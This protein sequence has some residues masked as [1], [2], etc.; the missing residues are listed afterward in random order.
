[1]AFLFIGSL[2][3]PVHGDQLVQRVF[4]AHDGLHNAKVNDISFD[5]H[6]YTWLSTEEG[7]Y[8]IS[9][10]KSRR[11]DKNVDGIRLS[12]EFIALTE[13]LSDTHLLVS[14][15]ANTYLYNMVSDEFSQFGSPVL[16]SHARRS[17]LLGLSQQNDG[18][19]MLLNNVGELYR[20]DYPAMTLTFINA[21]P[22]DPDSKWL[23]L[24][25]G[26]SNQ[27]ILARKRE[28]QLR[29]SLGM[30]KGVFAW[31]EANGLIKILF[32][33]NQQ[34]V[35]LGASSGL[36]RV[37]PDTLT[38]EKIT[39]ASFHISDIS[40][41]KQ[42]FLWLAGR[43]ELVKWHPDTGETNPLNAQ[44]KSA[45]DL[46]YLH[47]IAVDSND[48]IWVG[49]SGSELALVADTAEFV[50]ESYTQ[51]PPYLLADDMVWTIFSQ[52][53]W[54]W[55]GTDQGLIEINRQQG[56]SHLIPIAAMEVNDSVY[57]I[58]PLDAVHLLIGTT[59]GLFIYNRDNKQVVRF[60]QWTGGQSSLEN[61]IIYLV[62]HDPLLT[63][64]WWFV[65][66]T[67]LFYW[68][69]G[70]DEV[71]LLPRQDVDGK[72]YQSSLRTIYRASDGKLWLGGGDQF[73][74][75]DKLGIYYSRSDVI[76]D[77]ERA[78]DISYISEVEPGLLWLGTSP[79]GLMEYQ[80][81]TGLTERLTQNW[82]LECGSV[83]FIEQ[84]ADYR[85]VGCN[86]SLIRQTLANGQLLV[87]EKQDGLLNNE[88]NDGASF[89]EPGVGLYIGSPN[90]VELIDVTK[91]SNRVVTDGIMLESM[92]IF[93]D[94]ATKRALL[95]EP[96]SVVAPGARM[97]SFQLTSSDFL[98]DAPLQL[99][100]RLRR[101]NGQPPANYVL[102]QGQ[103]QV[104]IAGLS[105]GVYTL[106]ILSEQ[107]GVWSQT[108]FSYSFSVEDY[109]WTSEWFKALISLVAIVSGLYF[110]M[111]RQKQLSAFK[112][113]NRALRESE[114]RLRQSLRGSDSELWEWHSDTGLFNLENRG[115]N[116][117]CSEQRLLISIKEFPI[118][119]E[120]RPRVI[121]AWQRLL[122][123]QEVRIDV[124]YRYLRLDGTWGWTRVSGRPLE[125]DPVT[126]AIK[127]VAGI[128]SDI[129]QQ[130]RLEDDV[131]LLAQA[132]SNTSEGVLILD[133]D[134]R[135][136]VSNRAAQTI[137]QVSSEALIGC[138]FSALLSDNDLPSNMQA[139]N[140]YIRILLQQALTWTGE[141]S[142]YTP[143]KKMCPV[144]LNLSTMTNEVGRV[145]H[146]V[147]VFSD[148]S[149]RKQ[150]EAEL[151]R[152]ANYDVLTGLPNRTLFSARLAQSI[153]RAEAKDETL[154]L[155]FLD[156][157]RFKS[158]N[159]SYGH[160]MGDALLIEAAKRL[161]SCVSDEHTLCRFG[162]DE[163]LILLRNVND[164][165]AINHLCESLIR[166]IELPFELYGREFFISTSI[167][168]SLWP[169]DTKQAETL[170]KNA[171][172]AMYHAK[173]EGRGNFQ[174]YS[175]ERNAQSLY[176][177]K[178]EADLHKA[179][180]RE[181][182]ELHYQ[183]QIDML[184]DD[185]VVGM[186]ALLRWHHPEEGYIR[187]DIFIKVAESCGLII[188]IDR[189]VLK[190]ACMQG[191][192]WAKRYGDE[193]Q[194]SINISAV[195]FRQPDF[196]QGIEQALHTSGMPAHMLGLEITEGVLMKELHIAKEHLQALRIL[197]IDVAIDDFGTGY[198]SLAYLRSFDVSTL[199]VDRSFL[200]DIAN[201]PA[202]QAIVSSIIELARNL[203]LTVVAE[204]VETKAQLE[205]VFSRGCYIIQGYYYA[206]PMAVPE[207]EAYLNA[208]QHAGITQ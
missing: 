30:L 120:D 79:N 99:Q 38:V 89:Y 98:T 75:I 81:Q 187:P 191:A 107:N 62:Y 167:G 27:L 68:D 161:Q 208:Q 125:F 124:D 163:F 29:D 183:P 130:R 83:Y 139:D 4:N 186:E 86:N 119:D 72:R 170:I 204:G 172:Q 76:D 128:Y 64:R 40:Q 42:G 20:F 34:R 159:D 142:F 127:K 93:F 69:E 44:L 201:N 31:T 190:Q 50:L 182:F 150:T 45:A 143:D 184:K 152:L 174:Y 51:E 109:W 138:K 95:P 6:G 7:L 126:G 43:D 200:I 140:H 5:K 178:L 47:A 188:D 199:K 41:D 25:V 101:N 8:R 19:Y 114:E 13:P 144:W 26:E 196:I 53:E 18:S 67:G 11:I 147:A 169:D 80:P 32:E 61:K 96:N 74:Y 110:L 55:L 203:K 92:S 207:F 77:G 162:G 166:Q 63:Q 84:L 194:L 195:H 14:T 136:K 49:G 37:H 15:Y 46:N 39:Q 123:Q 134:E 58:K 9:N 105:A 116:F 33:D 102:L 198:S 115:G 59:N 179:I 17:G 24:S 171:D 131:K 22:H 36:Y 180:A 91:L 52:R 88:L 73:G 153:Q 90:G 176:H 189:W 135:V 104:N 197:G 12:D 168:V 82:Q 141:H 1:M 156:L 206:K 177:L 113:V 100:Y 122:N 94:G 35:W 111:V 78:V 112:R 21:L 103:S 28:L 160:S 66:A 133:A 146:F 193:L 145:S 60:A 129:T 121:K 181:E 85:I 70:T 10:T 173:E 118:H 57:N 106:D 158:V 175:A 65:T 165:D 185:R 71:S 108:P 157:D 97:I 205:Q 202:D 154:A 117:P 151:R 48:L 23:A 148:I 2:A 155:V 137:L 3:L 56:Q 16:F 132:F 54:L 164:I 192:Q 87:I 149:E